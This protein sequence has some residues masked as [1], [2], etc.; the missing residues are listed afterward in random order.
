MK[1]R[2]MCAAASI[3]LLLAFAAFSQQAPKTADAQLLQ[4]A[5]AIHQQAITIDT[6]VDIPTENYDPG[7]KSSAKCT[8]PKMEQGGIKGVFLAVYVGQSPQLN[9]QSYRAAYEAAMVKFNEIHNLTEKL[10]PKLCALATSPADVLRIVKTGK[11]AIMIGIENGFV[12]GTD[13][14]LLK[15]YYDLG[16]RYI[17]LCHN[18]DD[19]IC[20]SAQDSEHLNNG[21][22]PFGE[23][24][25]AEMNRLGIMVDVSHIGEK[26]FWDVIQLAQ[27]PV[28]ASHSSCAALTAHPRNLTDEQLKAL[29]KNGGVV[30]IVAVPDFLASAARADAAAKL[31]KEIGLDKFDTLPTSKRTPAQQSEYEKLSQ[32]FEE[33]SQ[34][35]DAQ[36]PVTIIDFVNHIDHAVKVA[37]ID[38][39]GIGSDFDGGGGVLGFNDHSEAL[40]VTVELVRRGYS[41][42]DIDK[43]WGGN[44][45]RV[46]GEVEKRAAKK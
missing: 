45:L 35:I 19:Q 26:S 10:Y 38:H 21:L 3:A 15:R 22:S 8:L 16:A 46:W 13:L 33:R 2:N 28:I 18:G 23:Q 25:V 42:R 20:D 24:V 7:E 14:S 9:E 41:A 31:R 34:A 17:T 12:I 37:G 11:R 39:V 27:A 29:S 44:L 36:Y 5:K 30:Q 4:K 32:T 40:N 1:L 43:I 6:H